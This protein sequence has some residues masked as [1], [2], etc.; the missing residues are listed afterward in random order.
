MFFSFEFK[1]VLFMRH[2]SIVMAIYALVTG[3]AR[4]DSNVNWPANL[5]DAGVLMRQNEQMFK[6]NQNQRGFKVAL[7]PALEISE[8][9][10][11]TA[12]HF[13]FVGAKRL[14]SEELT[15]VT[16]QFLHRPLNQHELQHLTDSV[17]A[18]YRQSGWLVRVY[19]PQQDVNQSDI[20]I[21][22][23]ENTPSSAR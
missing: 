16:D 23:L 2:L 15:V 9:T 11:I 12:Q 5:P 20:S 3:L 22:I 19:I 21:L 10:S 4:A 1:K 6:P 17:A 8:S 7:P 13:N 14:S 18:R